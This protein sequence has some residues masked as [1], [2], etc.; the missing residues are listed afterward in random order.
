[1]IDL[2]VYYFWFL[3][4]FFSWW[5]EHTCPARGRQGLHWGPTVSAV[6]GGLVRVAAQVRWSPCLT[7]H[8]PLLISSPCFLGK[9]HILP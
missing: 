8:S 4:N 1:M 5:A 3:V 6:V 9:K 7:R 2:Y